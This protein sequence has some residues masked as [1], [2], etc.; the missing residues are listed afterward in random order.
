M[1]TRLILA[2][3]LATGLVLAPA[4]FAQD[5]TKP[6]ISNKTHK[7]N[8]A[9][10][11]NVRTVQPSGKTARPEEMMQPYTTQKDEMTR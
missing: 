5:A 8:K 10:K 3:A 11:K 1:T 9:H 4:A 6:A 2:A 7:T